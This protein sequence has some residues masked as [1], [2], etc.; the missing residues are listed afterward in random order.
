[1]SEVRVFELA[2]ELNM[3]AKQ[4]LTKIRKAGIPVTGNFSEL[5]LD[6][7]EIVRK[8]AKSVKGI[9]MPKAVKAAG[10]SRTKATAKVTE[11]NAEGKQ[12]KAKKL[13]QSRLNPN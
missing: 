13:T 8:M 3:P 10:V 12:A 9:V 7:A 2:K 11:D 4:L 6:Q 1:M 5:S